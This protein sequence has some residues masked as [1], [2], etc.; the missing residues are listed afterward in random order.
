MALSAAGGVLRKG[1]QFVSF[2]LLA[3]LALLSGCG[4][5]KDVTNY[6]LPPTAGG[7]LCSHECLEAQDYCHRTCDIRKR[8]C[9]ND[10]QAR[11]IEDYDKYTR[12]QYA[13]HLPI[14]LT[15]RDFERQKTCVTDRTDCGLLCDRHYDGCFQDCGGRISVTSS[16]QYLC[17]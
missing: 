15:P 16:C 5:A 12:E 6:A 13:Q 11:A 7:R 2:L 9:V 1:M 8:L 17:F 4:T 10:A 3:A 14:E